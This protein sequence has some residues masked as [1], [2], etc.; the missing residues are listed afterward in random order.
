MDW[1]E[2]ATFY[3]IAKIPWK[4]KKKPHH[5]IGST[6]V[7]Y[8]DPKVY[9]GVWECSHTACRKQEGRSEEDFLFSF[10]AI[11]NCEVLSCPWEAV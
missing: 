2:K 10:H 5:P 11:C 9:Q 4:T 7:E 1:Q 6:K 3:Q 8:N